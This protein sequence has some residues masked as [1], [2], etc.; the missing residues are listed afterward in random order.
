MEQLVDFLKGFN[1]QTILTMAFIVWYFTRDI[2]RDIKASIDSLDKDVRE[3]NA[4][5]CR[6]E[7]TVYGKDVYKQIGEKK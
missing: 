1:V 6:L 5:I 2:T 7:G 4:R 3:M